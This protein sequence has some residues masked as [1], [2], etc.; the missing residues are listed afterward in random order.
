MGGGWNLAEPCRRLKRRKRKR[1]AEGTW[2]RFSTCKRLDLPAFGLRSLDSFQLT[3]AD[4][5]FHALQ[6]QTGDLSATR[7]VANRGQGF[8][9]SL[10][11]WRDE[12]AR[13]QSRDC[14][15]C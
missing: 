13:G 8:P 2:I 4:S 12:P 5:R 15:F 7:W 3:A 11:R 14:A 6:K 9:P 1:V 10:R